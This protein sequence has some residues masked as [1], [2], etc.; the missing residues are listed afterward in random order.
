MEEKK[1]SVLLSI[2]KKENPVFL[3][4]CLESILAQT[5]MPDEIVMVEDGALT[6]ELYAVLDEYEKK[7]NGLLKRVR[8]ETNKGLGLALKEGLAACTNEFIARMDT[9]DICAPQRF[10]KQTAYLCSDPSLSIV[11]GNIAEFETDPAEAAY[12]RVVPCR[13]EEI[14]RYMKK[15]CPFNHGTVMFRKSHVE[16][17]GGYLDWKWNEDYYLWVRMYLAGCRFANIDENLCYVRVGKDMYRRRGGW[18]YFLS[19]YKLQKFMRKNRVISPA[20]Y[21]CNVTKRFILQVMMPNSLRG[22]IFKKFARKKAVKR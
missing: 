4:A 19:E 18:Q 8:Y 17:A 1:F 3:A 16:K 12:D 14:C 15:R 7:C 22:W 10:E 21:L 20:T 5:L 13:H 6:D 2:Y 11:G 9:D